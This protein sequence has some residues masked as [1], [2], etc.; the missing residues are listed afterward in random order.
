LTAT[1][2]PSI[3]AQR[4]LIKTQL[5]KAIQQQALAAVG[6]TS[7][8]PRLPDRLVVLKKL[9][10]DQDADVHLDLASLFDR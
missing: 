4:N 1:L 8:I 6:V 3:K 2:V 5:I 9:K 7:T 10:A